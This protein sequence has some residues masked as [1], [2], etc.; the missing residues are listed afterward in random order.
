M[1]RLI[2]VEKGVGGSNDL[3]HPERWSTGDTS[4]MVIHRR[5]GVVSLFKFP[6]SLD[7]QDTTGMGLSMSGGAGPMLDQDAQMARLARQLKL[8]TL[9][10]DEA[11]FRPALAKIAA[12]F[13]A[14]WGGRASMPTAA[15]E[16]VNR[17]GRDDP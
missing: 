3:D 4:S 10:A 17:Y 13:A 8:L 7:D 2:A 5:Y 12:M 15:I 1:D 6:A 16:F 14:Y 11:R 9:G